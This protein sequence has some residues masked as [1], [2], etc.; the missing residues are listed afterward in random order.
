MFCY[1]NPGVQRCLVV[2]RVNR[3]RPLGDDGT[4]IDALVDE[5]DRNPRYLHTGP[6]CLTDG[7]NPGKS[8]QKRRVEIENSTRESPHGLRPEDSHESGQHEGLRPRLLGD[9][10]NL[11]RELDTVAFIPNHRRLDRRFPS[12]GQRPTVSYIAD[13]KLETWNPGVDQCLE[14]APGA[15]GKNCEVDCG[16][17]SRPAGGRL[18]LTGAR[19]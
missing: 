17:L 10:T 13:H 2:A 8:R 19:R 18:S 5:V 9:V 16:L 7:I 11:L 12:T 4:V 3:D 15:A 1:L 6:Q 14:V